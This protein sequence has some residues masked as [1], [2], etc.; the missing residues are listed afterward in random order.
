MR[1]YQRAFFFLVDG[2]REDVFYDLVAR[3]EL[4]EIA[5]YLVE[6]GT[7]ARATTAFPS[8]TVAAYTPFLTGRYPGRS[9]VP[10]IRWFDREAYARHPFSL[11]RIRSYTGAESYLV[12]GDLVSD[13][14]T[15]FE[16]CGPSTAIF[17]GLSRGAGFF[18]N[19][20]LVRRIALALDYV[21]SG[22]VQGIDDAGR[23]YLLRSVDEDR[24]FVC[25]V[26]LAVDELSHRSSP[27][28]ERTRAA[29]H[30]VD[31]LIG[32]TARRLAARGQL[33]STLLC[34]SSDHGHA[35]VVEHF[36]LEGLCEEHFARPLFHPHE[37]RRWLSCDMACMVS[38]NGMGFLYLPDRERGWHH[39]PAGEAIEAE[40]ASLLD[41]LLAAPAID[42][43]A[44]RRSDG[45]VV[46][47]SQ[48]GQARIRQLADGRV[49][50]G[51]T[52]GD[53]FGYPDTLCGTHDDRVL[54]AA[55]FDSAYPDAPLQLVQCFEGAR[56]GDVVVT[57]KPGFDLRARFE[58]RPLQS[59]HGSLHR[60]HMRVPLLVSHP[61]AVDQPAR[62]VDLYPTILE[63]LGRQV[64]A[65]DGRSLVAAPTLSAREGV[66]A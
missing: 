53:P 62:T 32:E 64:P 21:R 48:R 45:T 20:A 38:G 34:L 2:A 39:R 1:T 56:S 44:V 59:G 23:D 27:F 22:N 12:D 13:A 5:R 19:K 31:R 43:V 40:H 46:V 3:G 57:A 8:V 4:P 28:S 61:G 51:T 11:R 50:Y 55:T 15:L 52:G 14:P 25:H 49:T 36:D 60:D 10:G 47:R 17:S 65:C 7:A 26:T 37:L 24:R 18:G 58:R 6:P 63:L 30:F 16:L 33:D 9:G 42:Q 54:H 35:D 29:Y 66:A 41:A